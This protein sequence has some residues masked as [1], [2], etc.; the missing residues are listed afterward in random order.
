MGAAVAARLAGDG[1]HVAIS[2]IDRGGAAAVAETVGDGRAFPLYLDVVDAA[3]VRA[4]V[5]DA[6]AATGRPPTILVYAAGVLHRTRFA[7]IPAEEFRRSM[8][9][10]LEGAFH[11]AQAVLPEMRRAGWGR[12][13]LFSSTAGKSV[14]TLGGVHYTAAKAGLLGLTRG[15]AAEVAADGVTVNAV[16]PG[17]IETPMIVA[18]ASGEEL[19][20][21]AKSFPVGRLGTPEEVAQLVS[22]LCSDAASYITGA[23]VDINGGDLMI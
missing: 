14:S 11:C 18:L 9:V 4:A 1:A 5:Q 13:V 2:D 6:T 3:T 8:A 10:N 20:D 15:I 21:Y 7:D 16:C 12:M 19:T 23:A 17:L 22:F